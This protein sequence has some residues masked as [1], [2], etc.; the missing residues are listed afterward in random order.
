[1]SRFESCIWAGSC[2]SALFGVLTAAQSE[3]PLFWLLVWPV[4]LA[5][6]CTI[7]IFIRQGFHFH[8]GLFVLGR[9]RGLS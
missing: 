8:N 7:F 9:R 5:L 3:Q 2:V 4:P 6:A 1:M